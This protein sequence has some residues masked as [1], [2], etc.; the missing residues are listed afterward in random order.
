MLMEEIMMVIN[1]A[2]GPETPTREPLINP[3]T[4]PPITPARSPGKT[5]G[6]EGIFSTF[7]EANPIPRQSGKA[8]KNTT[9]PARKSFPMYLFKLFIQKLLIKDKMSVLN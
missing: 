3:T 9:K 2:A 7:V 4:I 8:T 5:L 6:K 1:P